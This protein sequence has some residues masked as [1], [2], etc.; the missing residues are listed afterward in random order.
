ML[1][2]MLGVFWCQPSTAAFYLLYRNAIHCYNWDGKL[3]HYT[4]ARSWFTGQLNWDGR[5]EE[6]WRWTCSYREAGDG[7]RYVD[8]SDLLAALYIIEG[9]PAVGDHVS[10]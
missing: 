10:F 5:E 4:T 3:C 6:D 7:E 9:F 8:M 2:G 1:A